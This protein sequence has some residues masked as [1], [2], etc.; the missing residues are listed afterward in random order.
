MMCIWQKH[1]LERAK[2]QSDVRNS[3]A[4]HFIRDPD[5]SGLKFAQLSGELS[6]LI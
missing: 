4:I 6:Q 3:V 1:I 5:D 2:M